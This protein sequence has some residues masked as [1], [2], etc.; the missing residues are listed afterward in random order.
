MK[1]GSLVGHEHLSAIVDECELRLQQREHV[2]LGFSGNRA[3][4]EYGVKYNNPALR[5][6][7]P[8]FLPFDVIDDMWN[9]VPSST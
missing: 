9:I 8:W 4:Q 6:Q 5:C 1:T 2:S 7:N 3:V